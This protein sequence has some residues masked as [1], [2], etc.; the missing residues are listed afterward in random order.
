L[1]IV[2]L[3]LENGADINLPSNGNYTPLISAVRN[4]HLETVK[5]LLENGPDI[6][7]PNNYVCGLLNSA[8]KNGHLE[9]IKLLLENGTDINNQNSNGW[10]P[11]NSAANKIVKLL[12]D[13]E[14]QKDK[15]IKDNAREAAYDIA[16]KGNHNSTAKL[17]S[18]GPFKKLCQA[19]WGHFRTH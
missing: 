19:I 5:L 4:G 18:K 1:E 7:V 16:I 12:L 10:T 3:L 9:I 2:K 15:D 11:L 8:A 17:P 13:R 14:A 6:S